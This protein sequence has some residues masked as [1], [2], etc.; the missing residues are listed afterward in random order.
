MFKTST[1]IAISL[2]ALFLAAGVVMAQEANKETAAEVTN[3]VSVSTGPAAAEATAPETTPVSVGNK[4]CPVTGEKIEE[5]G[6]YTVEYKGKVYNLC[7]PSCQNDFLRDPD[8]YIA[9]VNEELNA[10]KK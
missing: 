6:K 3:A 10:E 8:K 9:K 5:L 7:C 1:L 4:I 2:V